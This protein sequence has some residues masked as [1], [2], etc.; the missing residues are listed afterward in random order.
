MF[1]APGIPKTAEYKVQVYMSSVL[2]NQFFIPALEK[3]NRCKYWNFIISCLLSK[4]RFVLKVFCWVHEDFC[5]LLTQSSFRL[6]KKLRLTFWQDLWVSC[7]FWRNIFDWKYCLSHEWICLLGTNQTQPSL[8]SPT[9]MTV[10]L[11]TTSSRDPL[12]WI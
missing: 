8:C 12:V 11:K 10:M 5:G 4:G 2:P 6:A 1:F 3:P 9:C 7:L